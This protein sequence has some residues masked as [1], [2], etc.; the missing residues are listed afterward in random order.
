MFYRVVMEDVSAVVLSV[1]HAVCVQG[2]RTNE[3]PCDEISAAFAIVLQKKLQDRAIVTYL[4]LG[5]TDRNTCDLNRIE[6]RNTPFRLQL[7]ELMKQPVFVLDI[8]SFLSYSKEGHL[9]AYVIQNAPAAHYTYEFV[10]AIHSVTGQQIPIF[11]AQQ[12]AN[13]IISQAQDLGRPALL[14][15]LNE[16]L[17]DPSTQ[18]KFASAIAEW[19]QSKIKTSKVAF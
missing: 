12:G 8:H 5:N 16:Q 10:N 13:D 18:E 1:P 2:K 4:Q 7:T 17:M 9:H 15:E 14:L 11:T 19:F 3:Y 6:C